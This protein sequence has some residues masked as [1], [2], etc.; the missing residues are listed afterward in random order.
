VN[1]KLGRASDFS[2]VEI[3]AVFRLRGVS[4]GFFIPVVRCGPSYFGDSNRSVLL[5]DIFFCPEQNRGV[6]LAFWDSKPVVCDFV[7]KLIIM[8]ARPARGDIL[9]ASDAEITGLGLHS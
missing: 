6:R 3:H 7:L 9:H 5:A 8:A 4:F 2:F 1:K